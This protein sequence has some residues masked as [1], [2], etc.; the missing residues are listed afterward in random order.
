VPA[1]KIDTRLRLF[2][3]L[4]SVFIVSLTVGDILG[5]KLIQ[6]QVGSQVFTMTVGMIPFPVTFLLTDILNEFYG[7]R[8]ARLV[9]LVGF[10]MA[11]LSYAFIYISAA[12]PFAPFTFDPGWKGVT[13]DNFNNVFL[14]SQRMIA[15]SMTAYLVAQ[16]ADIGVF[17]MI[18]R[19]TANRLLWLRATGSTVVSQLIDTIV[20]NTVAW[21]GYMP[22]RSIVNIMVSSYVV[23]LVVAIALTP[24]IYAGH[25]LVERLLHMKPVVLGPDGEPI[26]EE[27]VADPEKSK[28]PG[29]SPEA[30][31]VQG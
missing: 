13:Q 12:V 24:A 21:I 11:V 22:A 1:V 30:F 17:H 28:A 5:G 15:A 2:L 8:A 19:L 20:I 25:T 4:A 26:E 23:K 27:A 7:K 18:K 10:G 3:T 9:T 14:G 31:K 16:F 29:P 6:G